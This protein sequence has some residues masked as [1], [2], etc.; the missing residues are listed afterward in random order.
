MLGT[1]SV[2]PM[3]SILGLLLLTITTPKAGAAEAVGANV[4]VSN[5]AGP[6]SE[7]DIAID[8]MSLGHILGGSNDI[9]SG[10]RELHAAGSCARSRAWSYHLTFPNQEPHE[11]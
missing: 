1:R 5:Q 2:S 3:R 7:T 10:E 6:Q 8:P 11:Q 9:S 4:N